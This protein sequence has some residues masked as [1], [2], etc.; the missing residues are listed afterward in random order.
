[1]TFGQPEEP[2]SQ[3]VGLLPRLVFAALVGMVCVVSPASAERRVALVIGN[4]AYQH[5]PRLDNPRSDANLMADTV[6]GLGFALVGNG[7]QVD[8]DK[9]AFDDILQKFGDQ[10]V[11][12]DVALFYYA[13]H[14]VQVR[15]SNYLVP[16][17][18]N[19]TREAD[20]LLQA[21]D[22]SLVLAAMEG[23]GTK[24]NLVLLD[25]CRNNPFAG[26]GL[27]GAEGGLA[28]MRAPEGTLIS[29]ATQPG[30]VAFDG[31]AGHSPYTNA[32]ARTIRKA[33]LDLFQAFNEVG[34]SVMQ[35]TGNSQQPW[36]SASP[37][38]G[39]FHFVISGE[40]TIT[41]PSAGRMSDAAEAWAAT[42]NSTSI[43]VLQA[44]ADRY[45]NTVYGRMAHARIEELKRLTVAPTPGPPSARVQ[46]AEVVP[47]VRP[48]LPCTSQSSIGVSTSSRAANPLSTD[49]EC[50]LKPKDVFQE[51]DKCPN[52]VVVPAGTFNM[53][54]P[55]NELDGSDREHPQHVVS[56]AQPL[57]VAK[58]AVTVD[59]FAA[60]IADTHRQA[61]SS[62]RTMEGGKVE[63]RAGRSWRDPGFPQGGTHPVVCI[64]FDD[65]EAYVDW[66]SARTGKRYRLLTEAEWEYT[67]RAGTTTRFFFGNDEKDLCRFGN[68]ADL[69]A[70]LKVPGLSQSAPCSD[71]YAYTAPV[72]SF[73]A[74]AFGLYDMHG[75]VRQ[76]V[77]DCFH[78][79]YAG[80]PTDG[81]AWKGGDCAARVQRGGAWGYRPANL[82]SAYRDGIEPALR[83]SF[84][85]FRVARTL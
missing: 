2:M 24:L 43:G 35:A 73:P 48:N 19:P 17:N 11:G 14:G 56:I 27:R 29:Y 61:G 53:G 10:M 45:E 51:C 41:P 71:G 60:F 54:S 26:R 22:T 38:K 64:N 67:A 36:V 1:M 9:A 77:E 62:C 81:S 55:A 57:G 59:Q 49:E 20:V 4:S 74:N 78:A 68:G 50:A 30:N 47:P 37:I 84:T 44:F 39:T 25:A 79:S 23:S 34:L 42:Q 75:N 58:F 52:M 69:A 80:A 28:Q 5:T 31:D 15:G 63:E 8:L 13:G 83:R 40:V 12:A 65:A 85:G 21:V 32:L 76:W 70:K 16:V 33:G 82:R 66:L 3:T 18:A 6:R 46:T 7:A 72:G